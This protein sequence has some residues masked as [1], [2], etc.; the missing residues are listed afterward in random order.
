M[1]EVEGYMDARLQAL[2]AMSS[3][4]DVSEPLRL[5]ELQC[6]TARHA[7]VT[8]RDQRNNHMFARRAARRIP[9]SATDRR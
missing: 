5:S 3:E 1:Y 6:I 9:I 8:P 4:V 2:G 7:P